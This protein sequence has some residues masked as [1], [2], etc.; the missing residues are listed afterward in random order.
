MVEE[1]SPQ[2]A[3]DE[4]S[5]ALTSAVAADVMVRVPKVH[6][7]GLTVRECRAVF[8]DDHIHMVLLVEDGRLLGTLVRGDL[9]P[10]VPEPDAALTHARLAGRTVAPTTPAVAARDEMVAAGVRRRAVVDDEGTLL[11]LLCLKH[12]LVG[13]CSDADVA[14][15]AADRD[16][17][18]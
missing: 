7:P 12:D 6:G 16:C 1:A 11:G 18:A 17:S 4:V 3:G 15:R 10:E 9:P 2:V 14:G 5:T 8:D 13:F